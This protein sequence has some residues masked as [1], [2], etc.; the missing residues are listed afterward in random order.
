MNSIVSQVASLED[1]ISGEFCADCLHHKSE[2]SSGKCYGLDFN[3]TVYSSCRCRVFN[4]TVSM[5]TKV[6]EIH[7]SP[8]KPRDSKGRA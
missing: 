7:N 1:V 8:N 3:G 4:S 5:K 2:F 6:Y